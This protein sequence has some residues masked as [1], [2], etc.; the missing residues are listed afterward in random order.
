MNTSIDN[1]SSPHFLY[2]LCDFNLYYL[3][4]PAP[5]IPIYATGDLVFA[6]ISGFT[7]LSNTLFILYKLVRKSPFSPAE[8]NAF[9][10]QV[11]FISR[12]VYYLNTSLSSPHLSLSLSTTTTPLSTLLTYFRINVLFEWLMFLG[13]GL[14]FQINALSF[15]KLAGVS[16]LYKPVVVAGYTVPSDKVVTGI[17]LVVV[18]MSVGLYSTMAFASSLEMFERARLAMY[19]VSLFNI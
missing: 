3:G 18:C 12:L 4:C 7:L 5:D 15:T 8:T 2:T 14:F 17:R 1:T 11:I 16:R 10:F 19:I 6:V 9:P 13:G